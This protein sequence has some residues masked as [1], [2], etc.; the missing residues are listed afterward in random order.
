MIEQLK[1]GRRVVFD[2]Q[3]SNRDLLE[4]H[5]NAVHETTSSKKKQYYS[6]QK[7]EREYIDRRKMEDDQREAEKRFNEI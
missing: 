1:F 2:K 5:L 4:T 3:Q 7:E 6:S